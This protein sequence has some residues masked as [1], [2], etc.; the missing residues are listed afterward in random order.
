M[1]QNN[2][3]KALVMGVVVGSMLGFFSFIALFGVE[4][5]RRNDFFAGIWTIGCM[6]VVGLIAKSLYNDEK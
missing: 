1:S 5:V 3:G 2:A 6:V 4:A